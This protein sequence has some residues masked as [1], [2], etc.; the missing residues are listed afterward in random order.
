MQIPLLEEERG[1]WMRFESS[2]QFLK[3]G[4]MKVLIEIEEVDNR[5]GRNLYLEDTPGKAE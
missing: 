1:D 3:E 2:L 4:P 5:R